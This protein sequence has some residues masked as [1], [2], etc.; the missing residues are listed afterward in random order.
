ME[1]SGRAYCSCDAE[2]SGL[3]C[4]TYKGVFAG[5]SIGVV[6]GGGAAIFVLIGIMGFCCYRRWRQKKNADMGA[7]SA[8]MPLMADPEAAQ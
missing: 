1:T 8:H 2:Y 7:A 4:D 5:L 3:T 6:S